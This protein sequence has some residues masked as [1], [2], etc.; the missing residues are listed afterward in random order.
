MRPVTV[1]CQPMNSPLAALASALE[2]RS[3]WLSAHD[4]MA[5]RVVGAANSHSVA[6]ALN[7]AAEGKADFVRFVEHSE[8]PVGEAYEAFI[9]RT[10][11]VPTRDNLHDLFNG[12]MWL[13]YPHTK[14][15]LNRLQAQQIALLGTSGPRGA[16]RDALTVFDENAG[17]LQGPA[18][19]IDALR[20]RDWYT[21]FIER[22]DEWQSARLM[23]FG[24]ALL[25]KLMRPRKAITAHVWVINSIDDRHVD[26]TL[27][28]TVTPARLGA[29]DF[30]PLPVLGV[31]GWWCENENASFYDDV[32]VFRPPR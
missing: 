17:I 12:L 29:K 27:A 15:R 21:L 2:S 24:H 32:E 18:T 13:S 26:E 23:L 25:E 20:R 10:G 6:E 14:R 4:A 5:R 30:L 3:P 11:R 1:K 31:P 8:L 9:A 28:S 22:R 7:A 16:L 19:L